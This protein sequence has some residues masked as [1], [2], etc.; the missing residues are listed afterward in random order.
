[1]YIRGDIYWV[2]GGK[3]EDTGIQGSDRPAI[4]VSN[5]TGN[6]HAPVVEVVFLTS[7]TKKP[8]P[9]H[10]SIASAPAPSTALCEQITTI[11]KTSLQ[12]YAGSCTPEE[13]REVDRCIA[14]SLALAEPSEAPADTKTIAELE[15]RI[16]ELEAKNR[17]QKN[18]Y[19][20][21]IDKLIEEKSSR[22]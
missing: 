13:M 7:R 18:I 20:N 6:I 10:C 2:K 12:R 5:N 21:M 15:R 1:M 11:S 17:I 14:I 16:Q 19:L 22:M 3:A 9:T 4:I 8:L